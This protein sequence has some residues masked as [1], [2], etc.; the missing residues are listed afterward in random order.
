MFSTT[1][2]Y[3]LRAL[4]HLACAPAE[5]PILGQ[6]L[7]QRANIPAHYLSKVLLVLRNAGLVETARGLGGG[8][9]LAKPAGQIPLAEV[10]KLFEGS[11]GNPG[12]LLDDRSECSDRTPCSAHEAWKNLSKAYVDF[13]NLTTINDIALPLEPKVRDIS[14]RA[15]KS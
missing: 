7:A 14:R 5:T 4:V 9:H 12:C 6:E 13:L 15:K 8:Y 11:G 1:T 2:R 10:V 3:A